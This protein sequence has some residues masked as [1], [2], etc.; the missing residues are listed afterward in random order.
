VTTC[1]IRRP[2]ADGGASLG[3]HHAVLLDAEHHITAVSAPLDALVAA[4][5]QAGDI[6]RLEWLSGGEL[7]W[8]RRQAWVCCRTIIVDEQ[9]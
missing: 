7:A 3:Y 6:D 2:L 4:R 1:E 8:A 9:A 5:L